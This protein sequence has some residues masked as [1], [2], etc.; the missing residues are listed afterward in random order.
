VPAHV[1]SWSE[2]AGARLADA[3][4]RRGGARAAV[5]ALLAEQRCALSAYEIDAKL[6]E[7]GRA[8]ARASVYRILDELD[9][10]GL[11]SRLEVGQGIARY[12]PHR[13][14]GHHHHHMVCDSCGEVIPFADDEL[15]E[16]I[17]RL[18]ERVTFEVAEHDITL[19]G[20]CAECR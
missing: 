8:V 7:G 17:D 13:P 4:F 11:V 12:E 9:G 10:L 18:A 19:H 14:D 16:T 15:E 3:G 20:S 2:H 6:R 5:I 1:D